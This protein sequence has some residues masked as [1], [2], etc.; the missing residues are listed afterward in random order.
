MH[1][2]DSLNAVTA[3]AIGGV[4][5]LVSPADVAVY[6]SAIQGIS[7]IDLSTTG[8]IAVNI[9]LILAID[10]CIIAPLAVYIASPGRSHQLLTAARG[11]LVTNQRR[12]NATVLLAFGVLLTLSGAVHLLT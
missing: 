5:L 12:L 6:L 10:V 2:L 11:W 9:G 4:L 3:F 8:R 1:A 7:G